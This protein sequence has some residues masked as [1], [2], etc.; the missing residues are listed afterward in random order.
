M[1]YTRIVNKV[2]YT[3]N[4]VYLNLSDRMDLFLRNMQTEIV[5]HMTPVYQDHSNTIKGFAV[6]TQDELNNLVYGEYEF[7]DVQI[8]K[9]K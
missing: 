7:M 3:H 8:V 2:Q 4:G 9:N 6:L 1:K 5:E